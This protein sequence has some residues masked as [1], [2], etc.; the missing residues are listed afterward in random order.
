M[1]ITNLPNALSLIRILFIPVFAIVFLS[2]IP[3]ANIWGL[4]VYFFASITDM[5][6][7]YFARKLNQITKLGKFLDP[8]ADK[9]MGFTMLICICIKGIIPWWALGIFVTKELLMAIG[10]FILYKKQKDIP[11]SNMQGKIATATFIVVC[12]VIILFN[13]PS[14]ISVIM[15]S[16][17]LGLSVIA[18]ISY[19]VQY[20][21]QIFHTKE[22]TCKE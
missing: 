10:G 12:I 8:L 3:N 7:G 14:N 20:G 22:G 4:V 16:I 18:L 6:D 9:L 11:P 21:N 1:T 2:D 15:I 17:A 5:F 19:F 13:I